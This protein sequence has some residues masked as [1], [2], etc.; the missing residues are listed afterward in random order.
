MAAVTLPAIKWRELNLNN[1]GEETRRGN[2]R[3]FWGRIFIC[4]NGTPAP[5]PHELLR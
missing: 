1:S 2:V 3:L 5:A 4:W